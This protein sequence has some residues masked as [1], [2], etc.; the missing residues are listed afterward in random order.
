MSWIHRLLDWFDANRRDLPWRATGDP[1]RIW[2]SEVMLQQTQVATVLPYYERFVAAFPTVLGL[3]RADQQR[4]LKLWEGLGY[5]SRARNLHK[6]AKA[7]VAEH[8]GVVPA[9][10][11]GLRAL[12]G[13][14]DY[15]AAAVA[16][17]A[18]GEAVPV[19]DGNVLRV[20][21]RLFGIDDDIGKPATRKA[22]ADRLRPAVVSVGSR[23][24]RPRKS[25]NNRRSRTDTG[26]RAVPPRSAG[27]FNQALMELGA[28]LC[29]PRSPDCKACPVA[30]WCVAK[31][32]G[33]VTELPVK[34]KRARVPHYEIAVA[35]IWR[36]GRILIGR[37]RADQMLGG[38]W[39][40]PGGK[41][42]AD[43]SL[44]DAAAREVEEETGLSVRVQ[45]CYGIVK[46]AYSHFS[47]AMS[48]FRCTSTRGRPQPHS[49]DELRW[50]A[51]NE[52]DEFPFPTATRKAIAIMRHHEAP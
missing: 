43:E 19:V 3:A 48:V 45:L 32:D 35:A 16:S 12:P 2:L 10:Y 39:E 13:V 29:T 34:A 46:H 41:R 6:A 31:R 8:D 21:A 4:V 27:D 37:R 17:I 9:D 22:I 5:Y 7:I 51:L 52:L 11:A 18:F 30:R 14:G 36:R 49:T 44:A 50:V 20:A 40:L 25:A 1:Y 33:R 38:L 15:T 47:I 23:S 42:R 26:R 24:S 28:L